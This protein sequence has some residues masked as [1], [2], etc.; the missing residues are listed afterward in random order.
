M[1]SSGLAGVASELGSLG[2]KRRCNACK[3]AEQSLYDERAQSIVCVMEYLTLRTRWCT[4]I[5]GSQ[6]C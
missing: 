1:K 6:I 2:E 3:R 4:A 5:E